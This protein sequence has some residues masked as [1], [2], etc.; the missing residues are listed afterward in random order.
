MVGLFNILSMAGQ[1]L[2]VQQE[3][4]AIAGQ[5]LANVNNPAYSRQSLEI[6][7]AISIQTPIGQEGTGVES[8][9]ITQVRSALLDSQIQGEASATGSLTT[10]QNVLENAETDLDEQLSGA[11]SGTGATSASSSGLSADLTKMFGYLQ[12]LSTDPSNVSDRSTVI[13]SAQAV[14]GQLNQVSAGLTTLAAGMD[15]SIESDVTGSNQD[16]TQIAA[17]NQ[18]IIQAKSSGGS[19]NDLV[20]LREKT[21]EDL[22][23]KVGFTTTAQP[24]G[25]TNISIGGVAMVAGGTVVD[26][27]QTY[28]NSSGH[29]LVQDQ[30]SS[31]PLALTGGSIEGAIT[32]RDGALANLQ[33]SLNTLAAQLITQVNTV[34][35]GG[36]DLKGNTGQNFFTGT[37]AATIGVNSTLVADPS[38]FQA[39]GVAGAS[40]D[41]TV[42]SALAQLANQPMAGLNNQTFSQNY[43]ATVGS[44]GSSLQ[45]VNEQLTNSNAVSQ[46]L[47]TQRDS[48]GGVNTDTEMTNLMQFQKAYEASAEMITTVNQMLETV[49]SMK[50]V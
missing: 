26:S 4:T 30:N 42:V 35:A 14:A 45:T 44:F 20:D 23:G 28:A 34:Y 36:Y 17:L 41:N 21:L 25:A 48:L 43:A 46:M 1:S 24:D 6:Q 31:A 38:T 10:Q 29:L 18:Q 13:Q 50:T 40:G 22:A 15:S 7:A 12:T 47:T 33:S 8:I 3:A 27:L 49:L 37:D 19:A 32:A 16:L 11:A 5:N 39:A 2:D 9:G